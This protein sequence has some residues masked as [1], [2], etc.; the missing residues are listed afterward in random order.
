MSIVKRVRKRGRTRISAK[1]QTTIPVAALRR[2]GL[3]P[4]DELRVEAAGAGRIVLT[5]VEET[6][7]GYAGRLTGVYPK[8][9]LQKLRREWR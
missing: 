5:R 9:S 7:A 1:N 4:G 3:K 8:G 6:L 2:A